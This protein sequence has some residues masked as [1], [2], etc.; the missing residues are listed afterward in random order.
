[1]DRNSAIGLTLIAVLLLLYFNFFSPAPKQ[2]VPKPARITA[3]DTVTSSKDTLQVAA[4][5]VDS[6]LVRQYGQLSSYLTGTE[7]VVKI[8]N[9]DLAITFSNKGKIK[10]VELKKFKTYSQK[11]LYLIT[12]ASNQ[13]ALKAQYEGKDIDLYR[14][15]YQHQNERH[16]DTTVISYTAKISES[17][18]L[19][20]VYTIPPSGYQVGYQLEAKGVTGLNSE[21]L[22]Y[23]WNDQ[24]PLQEKDIA[25]SRARTNVN[26]YTTAGSFEDLSESA[27]DLETETMATP[28]KWVAIRQKFFIS[29]IIAKNSFSGGEV[30]MVVANEFDS[31]TVK[32]ATV[33]L[34]IPKQDVASGKAQFNYF[35]GPNDYTV[36]KEV[37]DGFSR[38][39]PLGWPP[40]IWVNKFLIIPI[41]SFL[42]QFISN[43]GIIIILLVLIVK[44]MLSPLSYKSYIGMAK[45]KLLKPELDLIKEKY[46]DNMTQIQAEQMKLYQ[47][48]GVSPFSGCIPLLLQMPILFAMFYFFPFSIELRQEHF[49]WAEDLSTYDSIMTLPF[50]IPFYG[51]HVSLFVLLMTATTLITTWQNNQISTVQG[52]MK[53]MGYIMPVIFMFVLNKFSAGLSFYYFVSNLVTFIQQTVIKRFVD[54]DKIKTVMD[55]HRKK[56]ES[57]APGTGTKSKF[58]SKLQEA[59]KASE[60][61]KKKK[62]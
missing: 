51:S 10:E 53:S 1:M 12:A 25:D 62:K 14:L 56:M 18:Y 40:V 50:T 46:G 31:S 29:S 11:P 8:E 28:V 2:E 38:N 17:A 13:F 45:M 23:L 58:M 7:E 20:H 15:Y 43:Y 27:K 39:L 44:L 59:M 41:F 4:T 26:Y 36:V 61:N 47:Q 48:V 19:R 3:T 35:F 24:I 32:D 22:T 9:S 55:E 60:E 54:E 21:Q 57:G 42:E 30:S 52:P 16:G 49:L 37:T 33:K 34:F 6:S 5:A